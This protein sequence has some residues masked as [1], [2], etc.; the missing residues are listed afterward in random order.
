MQAGFNMDMQKTIENIYNKNFKQSF[1][2]SHKEDLLQSGWVGY[3]KA[4]KNFDS[5]KSFTKE[6]NITYVYPYVYKEMLEY[7]KNNNLLGSSVGLED[8]LDTEEKDISCAKDVKNLLKSLD[9]KEQDILMNLVG[10][11]GERKTAKMLANEYDIS[12]QRVYQIREEALRK[13]SNDQ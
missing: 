8:I 9:E 2:R 6:L 3:L 7:V 5:N 12:V 13:L 4:K 11:E 1:M 10:Y